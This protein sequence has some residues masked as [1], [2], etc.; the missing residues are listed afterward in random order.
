MELVYRNPL[1]N[2]RVALNLADAQRRLR[3]VRGGEGNPS[4][5][6]GDHGPHAFATT[7]IT[8]RNW[9]GEIVRVISMRGTTS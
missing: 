3:L 6:S 4:L 5:C 9:R 2:R 1:V 8:V 7:S